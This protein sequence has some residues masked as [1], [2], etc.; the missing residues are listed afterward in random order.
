MEDIKKLVGMINVLSS[1]A[2]II[3][4][5]KSRADNPNESIEEVVARHEEELQ[6]FAEKTLGGRIPENC[7]FREVVSGETIDERPTVQE[8]LALIENPSVK[9]VLVIEPSRLSRGDLSDCGRIVSSFRYTNTLVMTPRMTYD[10]TNKMERKFF[11]QE[12]MRGNDFLEYTKEILYAGRIRSIKAGAYIGNIPPYGYD[13][14]MIGDMHSLKPNDDADTVRLMFDLFTNQGYTLLEIA[15]H[16]ESMGIM[17]MRGDHWEKCSVKNMLKNHHYKGY[18]AFGKKKTV[19][20]VQDG[21]V[22]KKRDVP[23]D[24]DEIVIAKGL[25]EPLVSEELWERTQVALKERAKLSTNN[26]FDAPLKNPLAGLFWCKKCGRSI[27]QHPYKHARDRFECSNRR[28]CQTK[29]VPQDEVIDAIA[30]IL[31]NEKLPELEVK[32]KND[33]G[34]SAVIQK[35]QIEKLNKE[36][37][38][39]REQEQKQYD[40]LE[41][42]IYSEDK[43]L[44]RNKKLVAEMEELKTRIFNAKRELPKEVDYADK[45]V[46]LQDAIKCLR[47]DD[48]TPEQK[49][50]LLKAIIDRIEYELVGYEGLGKTKYKLHIF[51][52]L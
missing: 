12:L 11:E 29:S 23:A 19:K 2:Y 16:L 24:K 36:L 44:E 41:K 8:V 18:V 40:L 30:F 25:H 33:D 17:P 28:I 39:L 32:L 21:Q 35:K 15:K 45:I 38:Q 20:I 3:Y 42:G 6:E 52:L 50:R 22:I 7:I 14:C 1:E 43:F 31:E 46:K 13:K 34:K 48:M 26:K 51:L 10:L 47:T 5:R 49:N 9:A 27:K 4:L 37:D